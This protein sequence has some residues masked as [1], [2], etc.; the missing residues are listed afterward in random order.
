MSFSHSNS[1]PIRPRSHV[2][3]LSVPG[4]ALEDLNHILSCFQFHR[5]WESQ[6]VSVSSQE[7]AVQV[8]GRCVTVLRQEVLSREDALTSPGFSYPSTEREVSL[9]IPDREDTTSGLEGVG[10]QGPS[11]IMAG[12]PRLTLQDRLRLRRMAAYQR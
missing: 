12:P 2:V 5:G 10:R 11:E 9:L 1:D 3:L 8:V 7:S 6:V 4:E